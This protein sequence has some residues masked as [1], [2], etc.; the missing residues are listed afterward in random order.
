MQKSVSCTECDASLA[1]SI[2]PEIGEVFTCSECSAE[3]ELIS[4]DPPKVELAPEIQE[5]WGE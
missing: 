2:Q 4:V 5:D 3:L 1:L